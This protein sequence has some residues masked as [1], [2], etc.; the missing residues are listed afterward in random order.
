[1][2]LQI[3]GR[4]LKRIVDHLSR[5]LPHEGCGLLATGP[6]DGG[7]RR[8]VQF[9]PGDNI[10][11]SMTRFTMDPRQVLN[12]FD[13]I[14]RNHWKFGA[15]VHSHPRTPAS[16]SVTDRREAHYPDAW[17]MIV[18]FAGEHPDT[19]IWNLIESDG[20]VAQTEVEIVIL[21]D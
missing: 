20:Q 10:D 8:V 6:D 11:Q 19:R 15:I 1:M 7:T 9:Y 13:E 18:S 2:R 5:T 21:P 12:A 14:E 17:M 16:P 3:T 4:T